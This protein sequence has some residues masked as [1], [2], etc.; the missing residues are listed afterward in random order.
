MYK[1]QSLT[2]Y[3]SLS[4]N[5]LLLSIIGE[6]GQTVVEEKIK[7]INSLLADIEN[8]DVS[9]YS[10]NNISDE[11]EKIKDISVMIVPIEDETQSTEFVEITEIENTTE[12]ITNTSIDNTIE[13][14][15][16]KSVSLGQR[17][18]GC[19]DNNGRLYMWGNNECGQLGIG[20][21]RSKALNTP[22]KI[23]DNVRLVKICGNF[24][25]AITNTCLLYTSPSPRD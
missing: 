18:S 24:C 21:S 4:N 5:E 19:I 25:A 17:C 11:I 16:I 2:A 10:T 8:C 15:K 6:E 9:F 7:N 14:S 22:T 23:M 1:R 3:E 13:K 12:D 20:K